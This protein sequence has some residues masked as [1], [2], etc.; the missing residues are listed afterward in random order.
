[1]PQAAVVLGGL[2]DR[3]RPSPVLTASRLRHVVL[4]VSDEVALAGAAK[5]LEALGTKQ[6]ETAT[7]DVTDVGAVGAFARD[8]AQRIHHIDLVLVAAGV[9]GDQA[10]DEHDPE[11][12]NA[13]A[14]DQLRGSG[15]RDAYAFADVLRSQGAGRGSCRP[16]PGCGVQQFVYGSSRSQP[17]RFRRG[18]GRIAPRLGAGLMIVRPGWVASRTRPRSDGHDARRCG[19]RH[20]PRPRTGGWC[21]RR[22]GCES[23]SRALL[24]RSVAPCSR[25]EHRPAERITRPGLRVVE[26]FAD[27][28]CVH[29]RGAPP[30]G[31]RPRPAAAP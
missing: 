25:V 3:P 17:R 5:E 8:V 29:L 7:L 14:D 12:N 15:S 22:R 27:V 31:R 19:R 1:M 18:T 24:R 2:G 10:V 9:L 11:A 21:G 16:W 23:S 30:A 28:L 26:V 13:G 20:R 4:A 6:V